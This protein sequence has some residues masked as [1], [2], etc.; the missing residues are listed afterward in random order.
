MSNFL[1]KTGSAI[2]II[3]SVLLVAVPAQASLL[4]GKT[5][6]LSHDF[7]A[8]GANNVAVD[9]VVGPGIEWMTGYAGTY[10]VDVSDTSISITFNNAGGLWL[11]CCIFNG[12]HL[13]DVGNTVASFTNAALS[14]SSFGFPAGAVT[15]DADNIYVNF[16]AFGPTPAGGTINIELNVN[17]APEP[18]SI[19]LIGLGL[20]GLAFGRRKPA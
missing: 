4:L 8:M 9:E 7:P 16:A 3:A 20:F 19:A 1:S 18:A 13:N 5:V 6:R 2:A 17:P 14:S 10:Q 11:G 15:F 12:F